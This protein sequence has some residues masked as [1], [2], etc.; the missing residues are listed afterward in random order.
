MR[1]LR[2]ASTRRLVTIVA[3][4]VAAVA[5][6]GI[7]QAALQTEETPAPKPLDRALY[8]AANA[9]PVEGVTARVKFTNNLLPSG[10]LPEGTASPVL[11][12]ATG[13]IWLS[14]DGRL[15]L[16][17]QSANGDAQIVADG[18][19]FLIYDAAIKQAVTGKLD[20][21]PAKQPDGNKPNLG[22][23]QTGLDRLGQA[24][25]LSGAT[26]SNVAGRPSY[27]VRVAPKD[28]GGLLGAA[29][30]AWDAVRGVPLR[31]AVYAQG[32]D[33][34]VLEL[35]ATDISYGKIPADKV[36]ATPPAGAKVTEIDPSF[37]L[38]AQGKPVAVEGVD[39]V[40]KEL[41]F[42]LA[43]PAE[44]AGLPRKAVRLIKT[45][46]QVG[47]VSTYGQG[48]G[49]ILVFQTRAGAK[50]SNTAPGGLTLP[51]VNIDGATGSELATALGTLLTFQREGVQYVVVGSV[52]PIAA[53]N[54]ARGLR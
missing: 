33:N 35:E 16:E 28:D 39:A 18:E 50:S 24:W 14:N 41:D 10:S 34:P 30:V 40:Q 2:T 27:T 47:A 6:A 12:G 20:G 44:L 11:T 21:A 4:L 3:V 46:D 36:D 31:A 7:A 17:L 51:Q 1:R 29:E 23:I 26:P 42:P 22:A 15:R 8:D 43:A 48:L 53:E 45:D 52:P 25:T 13:R 54:A 19:R 9:K 38:D 49:Q 5:G 32:D 37:K